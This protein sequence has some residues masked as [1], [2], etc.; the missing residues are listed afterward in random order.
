MC[1]IKEQYEERE[2]ERKRQMP[3]VGKEM[4]IVFTDQSRQFILTIVCSSR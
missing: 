1:S 2:K 3:I 4:S